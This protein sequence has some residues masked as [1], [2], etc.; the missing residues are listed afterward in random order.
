MAKKAGSK[1]T[2]ISAEAKKIY[3]GGKS[4]MKW[5]DAIKK[6]SAKLKKEGNI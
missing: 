3:N 2:L 5:T 1:L 4:G 6:A